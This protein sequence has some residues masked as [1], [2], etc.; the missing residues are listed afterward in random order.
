VKVETRL[1]LV[2]HGTI[3]S[4][5][6]LCGSLDVPLTPGGRVE[7]A[8]LV[9]APQ[10]KRPPDALFTSPLT[11]AREVASELARVWRLTPQLA[12]WAREIDCGEFEGIPF[13]RLQRDFPDL[14]ARNQAQAEDT[15][16][17]PGGETY[18]QFRA[19]VLTGLSGVAATYPAGRVI[20]VT[21]AGVVSQ[22][23]GVVRKRPACVWQPDRPRPL[24]AT[25]VLWDGGQPRTVLSFNDPDWY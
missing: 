14:W 19:R 18:A 7:L 20:V 15:F 21:H 9:G 2:R 5:A 22:V 17:W 13:E 23:L 10:R 4:G 6:R 25:E 11:R 12:D 8:R 24:S 3:D 1:V 16:A